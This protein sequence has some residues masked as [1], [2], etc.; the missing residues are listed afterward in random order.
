MCAFNTST[1]NAWVPVFSAMD[2]TAVMTSW[3]NVV[4]GL[5]AYSGVLNTSLAYTI[6]VLCIGDGV[7]ESINRLLV[8]DRP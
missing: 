3:S 4:P 1:G 6:A 8:S 2:G 5:M 7:P